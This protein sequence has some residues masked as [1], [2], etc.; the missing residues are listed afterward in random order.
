MGRRSFKV[1]TLRCKNKISYERPEWA[2][3][4]DDDD[5]NDSD[6]GD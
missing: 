3:I 2:W 6:G 4:N 5:D 1:F